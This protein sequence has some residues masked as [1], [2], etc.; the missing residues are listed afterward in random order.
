MAHGSH[1]W[2]LASQIGETWSVFSWG[3]G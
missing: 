3:S 1:G 2:S